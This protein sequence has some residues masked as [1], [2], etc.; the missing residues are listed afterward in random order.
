MTNTFFQTHY[1]N[2]TISSMTTQIAT[3]N[4]EIQ[5]RREADPAYPVKKLSTRMKVESAKLSKETKAE[6]G[7][8]IFE[9]DGAV[10]ASMYGQTLAIGWKESK[11]KDGNVTKLL[12]LTQARRL[13]DMTD[14]SKTVTTKCTNAVKDYIRKLGLDRAKYDRF[15]NRYHGF[16]CNQ[17]HEYFLATNETYA[18]ENANAEAAE[19][20]LKAVAD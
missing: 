9:K 13:E 11:D 17:L 14:N 4:K 2:R 5:K 6:L 12:N 16:L 8:T 7:Y 19:A 10:Y 20:A 1:A 3:I 15:M 18:A